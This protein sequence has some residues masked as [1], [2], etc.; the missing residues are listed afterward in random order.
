MATPYREQVVRGRVQLTNKPITLES[1]RTVHGRFL[2][3]VCELRVESNRN[4]KNVHHW[5]VKLGLE[6][7]LVQ[8]IAEGSLEAYRVWGSADALERFVGFEFVQDWY[9]PTATRVG[10]QATGSG[11]E[12]PFRRPADA[13]PSDRIGQALVARQDAECEAATRAKRNGCGDAARRENLFS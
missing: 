8:E 12:K 4:V 2:A 7:E 10:W 5:L 13:R 3:V 9:L 11:A 6:C 1:G